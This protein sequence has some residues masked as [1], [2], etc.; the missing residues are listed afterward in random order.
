METERI[1]EKDTHAF[2]FHPRENTHITESRLLP[3]QMRIQFDLICQRTT[4]KYSQT[5]LSRISSPT[6][7]SFFPQ[8]QSTVI[9]MLGLPWKLGLHMLTF[10]GNI[11]N[12]F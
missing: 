8:G 4:N 9:S 6:E 7:T 5:P 3:L 12:N 2:S 11:H 10:C 1:T